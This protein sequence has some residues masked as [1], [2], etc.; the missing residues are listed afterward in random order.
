MEHPGNDTYGNFTDSNFTYGNHTYGNHTYGNDTGFDFYEFINN[1]G[2]TATRN[3]QY[4]F[5][6]TSYK[7]DTRK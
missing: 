6:N 4:Y 2:N 5:K 1:P 3:S 7:S